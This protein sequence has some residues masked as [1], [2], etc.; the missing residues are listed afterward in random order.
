[1]THAFHRGRRWG[2]GGGGCGGGGGGYGALALRSAKVVNLLRN[3][4]I[5]GE[6]FRHVECNPSLPEAV[7]REETSV[8]GCH[9]SLFAWWDCTP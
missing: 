3:V 1:M 4:V 7:P 9:C 5:T 8:L 2:G 6:A